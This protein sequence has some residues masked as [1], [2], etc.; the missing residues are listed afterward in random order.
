MCL[1]QVGHAK[2]REGSGGEKTGPRNLR[3]GPLVGRA[4]ET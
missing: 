3:E 1:Q 2:A 4:R